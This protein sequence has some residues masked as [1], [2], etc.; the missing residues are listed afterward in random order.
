M[1]FSGA[2]LRTI[3]FYMDNC[4][5]NSKCKCNCI[6][7]ISCI[8]RKPELKRVLYKLNLPVTEEDLDTIIR[9][10]DLNKDGKI[11]FKGINS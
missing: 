5:Y 8:C 10:D 9:E 2:L 1:D 11:D 6:F 3:D 7:L 4:P